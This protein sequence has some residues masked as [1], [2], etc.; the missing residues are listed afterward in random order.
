MDQDYG[1]QVTIRPLIDKETHFVFV[2]NL[3]LELKERT[4]RG[5]DGTFAEQLISYAIKKTGSAHF[6]MKSCPLTLH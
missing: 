1:Y 3:S 6:V 4:V 2:I 5:V